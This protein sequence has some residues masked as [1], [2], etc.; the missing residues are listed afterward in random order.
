MP[1]VWRELAGAEFPRPLRRAHAYFSILG[2]TRYLRY[3]YFFTA[4]LTNARI[5]FTIALLAV[6]LNC[7][8][9]NLND[10][11]MGNRKPQSAQ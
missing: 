6:A 1:K 9:A 4:T 2:A 8:K 5:T 10:A 3:S 7:D 11:R